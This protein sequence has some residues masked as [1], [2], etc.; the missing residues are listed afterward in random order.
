MRRW[1]ALALLLWSGAINA[2][3]SGYY[4]TIRYR[5][6]DPFLFCTQG[7]D[8]KRYP[9]RCWIPLP[10][11]TGNY[12]MMPYCDPPNTYGKSW[13]QADWDSLSQYQSV[14]PKARTSGGWEGGGRPE[15]TPFTH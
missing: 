3:S 6:D 11:Y 15:Q 1:I 10:P 7:Q 14:C 9:E 5:A 4:E 13:T 2:Q 8:P 12:M